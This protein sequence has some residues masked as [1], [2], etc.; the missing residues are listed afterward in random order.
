MEDFNHINIQWRGKME[1]N[2]LLFIAGKQTGDYFQFYCS[3]C[4]SNLEW[5]YIGRD[6]SIPRFKFFCPSCKS[7]SVLKNDNFN[8]NNLKIIKNN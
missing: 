3:K 8:D 4:K 1:N 5:E 7:D 2:K 6:P